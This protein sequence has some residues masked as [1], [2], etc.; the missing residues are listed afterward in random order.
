MTG[1]NWKNAQEIIS[2]VVTQLFHPLYTHP[3]IQNPV[4][5]TW[6]NLFSWVIGL[7]RGSTTALYKR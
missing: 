1:L 2:I 4:N 7:M 3:Y 6:T 5:G